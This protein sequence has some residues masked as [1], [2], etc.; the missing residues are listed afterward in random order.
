MSCIFFKIKFRNNINETYQKMNIEKSLIKT[1]I[2]LIFTVGIIY[3]IAATEEVFGADSNDLYSNGASKISYKRTSNGFLLIPENAKELP[4]I[5]GGPYLRLKNNDIFTVTGQIN[6]AISKDDGKTW[7]H[8]PILD[9]EKYSIGSPVFIETKDGVIIIAYSNYK[10]K[11]WDWNK[12]IIDSPNA[13]LPTYTIRSFDSGKTWQ[14]NQKLH[15]DWTGAIRSIIE[16]E[17]GNIIFTTM[18]LKHNP[19]SHT[20]LTYTSSDNA[21]TWKRSNIL[22]C[23]SCSGDHSGLM[24][25]TI[26]QLNDK[27]IWQL[28][29]TNWGSFY[30]SFSNDEGLTWSNPQKTKIDASSSP[31]AL[32]RLRSGRLVLTWNRIYIEDENSFPLMGGDENPNLS[33]VPASWQRE[34]LSLAFS[35]DDGKNWT[36]PVV[37]AKVYK[38][39]LFKFNLWDNKRWLAYPHVFEVHPGKLWITT[40]FGGVR[41][42]IDERDF[43]ETITG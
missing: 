25:S 13:V 20:V 43:A 21:T 10:E 32:I 2:A 22:A 4:G 37:I 42:E 1:F 7:T 9:K 14:D 8:Y 31:A 3:Y 34:E 41:I 5:G 24:E 11:F 26:V 40:D 29:R 23:E 17:K 39:S 33:E 19:G 30:E 38:D 35:D 12:E 18:K 36:S 6:A 27:R 28:I 16:T 15:N